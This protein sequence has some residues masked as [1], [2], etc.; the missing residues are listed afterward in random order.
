MNNNR[1][2]VLETLRPT[3]LLRNAS[4]DVES[5]REVGDVAV[6]LGERSDS[7]LGR[8]VAYFSRLY[9]VTG[10]KHVTQEWKWRHESYAGFDQ[11]HL[12]IRRIGV[13]AV[14]EKMVRVELINPEWESR[15]EEVPIP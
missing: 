9:V 3:E 11:P 5:M 13:I 10:G 12:F 4:V 7:R 2:Y 15:F 14:G 1:A 6:L 8:G